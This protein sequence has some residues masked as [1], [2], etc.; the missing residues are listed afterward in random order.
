MIVGIGTDIVEI[1]R[2]EESL[3]R[4]GT[5]FAERIL[6]TTELIEYQRRSA[7]NKHIGA[8]YLAKRFAAKEAFAKAYG[9]GIVGPVTWHNI[10]IT[11]NPQGCPKLNFHASLHEEMHQRGWRTWISLTDEKKIAQAFVIIETYE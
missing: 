6:M 2:I 9:T 7:G 11:N 8:A 5:A 10:Q 1:A 3:A 4:H